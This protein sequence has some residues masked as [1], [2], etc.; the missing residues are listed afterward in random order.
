MIKNKFGFDIDESLTT[1]YNLIKENRLKG[2]S[3]LLNILNSK[4]Y[5]HIFKYVKISEDFTDFSFELLDDLLIE[6]QDII[7]LICQGGAI[8][9]K[10]K[11][12]VTVPP[13]SIIRKYLGKR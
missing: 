1:I 3:E 11:T 9:K 13:S 8:M 4:G 7:E 2:R 10:D 12:F 5:K 6:N